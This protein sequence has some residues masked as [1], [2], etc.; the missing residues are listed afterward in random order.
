MTTE[1]VAALGVT[2]KALDCGTWIVAS[3]IW[4]AEGAELV[5]FVGGIIVAV[6]VPQLEPVPLVKVKVPAAPVLVTCQP[7]MKMDWPVT[8]ATIWVE[9]VGPTARVAILLQRIWAVGPT[10]FSACA[11]PAQNRR[12]SA[13]QRFFTGYV[14]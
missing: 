5:T 10:V 9:E 14:P 1:I 4:S 2:Q 6:P 3:E 8:A 13:A 11:A 7:Q 12:S